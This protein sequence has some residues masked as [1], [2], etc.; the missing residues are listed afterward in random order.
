MLVSPLRYPGGKARLFPFVAKIIENNSLYSS[1]YCEPYAGGAGL[2]LKLLSTGFVKRV[3]LNDL[4]EAIFAFWKSVLDAPDQFCEMIASTKVTIDEWHR[5]RM[6]WE[7]KDPTDFLGLGFSVFFL[8]RTSRSGIIDGSGPI[9]GYSQS[10]IWKID[11]RLN[12]EKH[13]QNIQRIKP[14]R[15][16]ISLSMFDAHHYI[17]DVF[18]M[19]DVFIYLDPP[20]YVKGKKLYR[21]SYTHADHCQIGGCLDENRDSRW[22]VSYDDV[23]E[24][25]QIYRNF[26]PTTYEMPYSAG[27]KGVGREVIFSSD[28]V[29]IPSFDGFLA[30]DTPSNRLVCA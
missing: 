7:R 23:P 22:I 15:S 29:R 17:K 10:G 25:R 13:I 26:S 14:F 19:R 20:Y 12:K 1:T 2:A 6:V 3:M 16:C 18:R 21:N 11:V 24:V 4:D 30:V 9:G 28:R 27:R 8:N 5:Q